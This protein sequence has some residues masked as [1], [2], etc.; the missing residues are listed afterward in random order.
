MNYTNFSA[1]LS[2][3]P[4]PSTNKIPLGVKT[5]IQ[6]YPIP[7]DHYPKGLRLPKILQSALRFLPYFI[8]VAGDE[9]IT[10]RNTYLSDVTRSFPVTSS[11]YLHRSTPVVSDDHVR[12]VLLA[13]LSVVSDPFLAR[14]HQARDV[15]KSGVLMA[16]ECSFRLKEDNSLCALIQRAMLRCIAKPI[17]FRC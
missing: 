14:V 12:R 5:S 17:Q 16:L 10:E 2:A 11:A 13:P 15:G 4:P 9:H 6:H 1:I 8:H 3:I 7:K